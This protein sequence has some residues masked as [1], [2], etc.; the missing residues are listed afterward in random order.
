MIALIQKLYA[1]ELIRY[2]IMGGLN[3]LV[4]YG[5]LALAIFLG[6]HYAIAG[7][8]STIA[9]LLVSFK[10]LGV[11]VFRNNRNEL[12]LKFS[13]VY[14]VVLVTYVGGIKLFNLFNVSEYVSGAILLVPISFESYYM[15]KYL[16][17]KK[18]KTTE[19][20]PA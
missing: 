14:F 19:D 13:I 18:T 16:V 9:Q 20:M 3:N 15:N 11:L 7:G 17:F 12:F 4:G 10:T 5:T 1:K 2:L 8:L 6:A